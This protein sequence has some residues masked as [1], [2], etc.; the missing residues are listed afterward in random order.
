MPFG[1]CN[2]ENF[3]LLMALTILELEEIFLAELLQK[4]S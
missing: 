4:Y 2:R 1:L 3:A